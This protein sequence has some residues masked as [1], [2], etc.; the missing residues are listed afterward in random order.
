MDTA[1]TVGFDRGLDVPAPPASMAPPSGFYPYIAFVDTNYQYLDAAW[2]DIRAVGDSA[3][4]KIIIHNPT[5]RTTIKWNPDSIPPGI[6]QI[7]GIGIRKF[8][9][10]YEVAKNE[11][12]IVIT[13]FREQMKPVEATSI[14]EFELEEAS[15]VVIKIRDSGGRVK[16][17][18]ELGTL[19]KGE[20]R[21]KW[22]AEGQEPGIYI[23][24]V[25]ANDNLIATGKIAIVGE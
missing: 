1:A 24:N 10:E 4:W 17:I 21:R 9:G 25:Y 15:N 20:Y 19:V 14:I 18:L 23:Y 22:N 5:D 3:E 2:A 7:N 13:Y 16:D 11:T 8:S 6:I 12:S